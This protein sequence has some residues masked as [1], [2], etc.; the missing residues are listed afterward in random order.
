MNTRDD[1]HNQLTTADPV[2]APPQIEALDPKRFMPP[3]DAH[4]VDG[5]M[6]AVFPHDDVDQ[7]RPKWRS[8][9][10][11]FVDEP[12]KAVEEADG[13]V[14]STIERLAESFAKERAELEAQWAK[15]S[16]VSTEDLRLAFRRYRSF[17]DRL[18]S[19]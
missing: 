15:G 3:A 10:I 1:N 18:L 8:I 13:L 16:N 4:A 12:R 11:K 19:A 2:S 9:Q 17:F 14:A 5:E 6:D 7:L